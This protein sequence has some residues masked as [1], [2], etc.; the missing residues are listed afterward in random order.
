[1][2]RRQFFE[3]G[4]GACASAIAGTACLGVPGTEA[5]ASVRSLATEL[6]DSFDD[7]TRNQVCVAYDHPL[8]QYH[9][10]GVGLGGGGG[11]VLSGIR[12][13]T[14]GLCFRPCQA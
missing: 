8:R 10:R 12:M 6:Y 14:L 7:A 2:N 5:L 9:N 3:L 13:R 1:M 11:D 4:A